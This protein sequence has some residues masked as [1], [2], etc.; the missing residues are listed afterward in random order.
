[1]VQRTAQPGEFGLETVSSVT[2]L[3][4]VQALMAAYEDRVFRFLLFSVRDR[5][6]ALSLTQDTFLQAWRSRASFRGECSVASWLMRIAVNLLRSH[7]RTEMFK[8]WRKAEQASVDV[9]DMQ[10]E[11]AHAVSSAEERMSAKQQLKQVWDSVEGLSKQQRTVFLLRFVEEMELAEIAEALTMPLP[12]VKTHLYRAL[13]TVRKAVRS[14]ETQRS[15]E[16]RTA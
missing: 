10:F 14:G 12:T 1:M 7:T 8:F 5:D 15:A 4:D 16:R 2:P 9:T 11:L 6:V 3:D 13:E